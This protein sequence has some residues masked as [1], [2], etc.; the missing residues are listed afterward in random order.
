MY[1]SDFNVLSS[2]DI[3]GSTLCY[4]DGPEFPSLNFTTVCT[5]NGRYVIY[6]NERLE[7]VIYAEGYE[8]ENIF[9]ELCE[10]IV[11]G[12]IKVLYNLTSTCKSAVVCY[13]VFLLTFKTQGKLMLLMSGK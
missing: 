12:K 10:V 11:Q 6:Y 7:G 4:K 9:T 13:K 2:A 5:E 1:V 3:K 8:V